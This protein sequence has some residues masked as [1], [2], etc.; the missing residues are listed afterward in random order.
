MK[1]ML[2]NK[3]G[4]SPVI[5]TVLMIVI[6]SISMS[7]LFAFAVNYATDFQLGRGSAVLEYMVIEDVWIRNST[8]VDNSTTWEVDIW[9]YN[10]GK[11]DLEISNV[12]VND[13][14]ATITHIDDNLVELDSLFKV[15]VGEHVKFSV[16]STSLHGDRD[17]LFKLFTMRGSNVEER[18]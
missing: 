15:G 13:Y 6:V 3:K 10:I 7:F 2:R 9:V 18:Y 17:N 8:T 12:Y 4:V 16:K 14:Q 1:R 5:A 11:V